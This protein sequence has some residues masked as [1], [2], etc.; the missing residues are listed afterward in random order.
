MKVKSFATEG[1][2][3]ISVSSLFIVSACS[4]CYTS[5]SSPHFDHCAPLIITQRQ[6]WGSFGGAS[7]PVMAALK[8]FICPDIFM[9]PIQW[10]LTNIIQL[11]S[12]WCLSSLP[13]WPEDDRGMVNHHHSWDWDDW[14]VKKQ[15]KLKFDFVFLATINFSEQLIN[16]KCELWAED[17]SHHF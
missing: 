2:F 15:W 13:E 11:A 1:Y 8:L 16:A 14:R 7:V 4:K 5:R 10:F 17:H 6:G 3:K 9:T 12:A